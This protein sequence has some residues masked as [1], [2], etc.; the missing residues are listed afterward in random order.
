MK[1]PGFPEPLLDFSD[2]KARARF[3]ENLVRKLLFEVPLGPL[4]SSDQ[5]LGDL[6]ADLRRA[7]GLVA[8][9]LAELGVREVER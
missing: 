7:W 2:E 8:E 1:Q 4:R 5:V 9:R 6:T 3:A